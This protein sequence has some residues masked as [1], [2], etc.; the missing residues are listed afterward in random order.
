MI[1]KGTYVLFLHIPDDTVIEVGSLGSISFSSGCYCYVGSA[2]SGLDQRLNRHLSKDKKVRWHIDRLT[3]VS[4][5]MY[6]YESSADIIPECD[7]AKLLTNSGAVPVVD[8][9]G[10]SDCDC[11]THL[12]RAEPAILEE[13]LVKKGL[14]RFVAKIQ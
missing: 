7:L 6:A 13:I 14:T 2:M 4:D 5:D 11:R 3:M 8:G 1:R 10:C 12:F 9:F